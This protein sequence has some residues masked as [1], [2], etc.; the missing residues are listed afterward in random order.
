MNEIIKKLIEIENN[1]KGITKQTDEK[2]ESLNSLIDTN[3]KNIQDDIDKKLRDNIF[4]LKSELY[5]MSEV[6]IKEIKENG[7]KT[8]NNLK[9]YFDSNH[10]NIENKIFNSIVGR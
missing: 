4:D 7:E 1:A 8:Y 10:E 6:K 2:K 9:L 5:R 3:L